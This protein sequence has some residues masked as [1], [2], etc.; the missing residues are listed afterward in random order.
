MMKNNGWRIGIGELEVL[1]EL[2]NLGVEKHLLFS[3]YS[4][5]VE[6]PSRVRAFSGFPVEEHKDFLIQMIYGPEDF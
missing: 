3:V 4:F 2:V 5:L 1:D 6:D